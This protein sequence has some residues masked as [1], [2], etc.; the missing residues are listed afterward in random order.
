MSRKLI[1]SEVLAAL[2][3]HVQRATLWRLGWVR[4]WWSATD[5]N[6]NRPRGMILM[7][8]LKTSQAKGDRTPGHSAVEQWESA[9]RE[10]GFAGL[11]GQRWRRQLC[12]DRL[13]DTSEVQRMDLIAIAD[14]L[15]A[16]TRRLRRM[17]E[18]SCRARTATERHVALLARVT[19]KAGDGESLDPGGP[20]WSGGRRPRTRGS[21]P[22]AIGA[23]E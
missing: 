8:L 12:V 15:D 11:A 21:N 16:I 9:F 10:F 20:P 3:P 4:R 13:R 19:G 2:P 18:R 17:V 5:K 14:L 23:G 7:E 1:A 6:P 22:S